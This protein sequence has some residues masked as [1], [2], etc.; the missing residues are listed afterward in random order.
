MHRK[1]A[2]KRVNLPSGKSLSFG[3]LWRCPPNWR[4]YP[5]KGSGRGWIR[6]LTQKEKIKRK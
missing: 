4:P 2:L 1:T 3:N 5:E 6:I